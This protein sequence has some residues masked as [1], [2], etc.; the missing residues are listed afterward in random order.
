M[1]WIEL[2]NFARDEIINKMNKQTDE[3]NACQELLEKIKLYPKEQEQILKCMDSRKKYYDTY[4]SYYKELC[5]F[6]TKI[7]KEGKMHESL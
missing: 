1:K 4:N 7:E 5:E 2:I 3:V 6:Q